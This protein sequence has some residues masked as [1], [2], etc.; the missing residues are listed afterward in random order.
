MPVKHSAGKNR[1]FIVLAIVGVLIIG[2]F[3]ALTFKLIDQE[4]KHVRDVEKVRISEDFSE[5]LI[6]TEDD[7]DTVNSIVDRNPNAIE[8]DLSAV[9]VNDK[10]MKKVGVLKRLEQLSL[11][12]SKV[13]DNGLQY[14]VGMPLVKLDLSGT[15]VTD[16][17][18]D[19]IAKVP[20]LYR[21]DL[22]VTKITDE[23][24]KKLA[25]LKKLSIIVLS[26]TAV[27]DA[28][29]AYLQQ[30]KNLDRI[31]VGSTKVSNDF[32]KC[33]GP[34]KLFAVYC[35]NTAITGDG[36]KKYLKNTKLR[37]M[38]LEHCDIADEDVP[39][40]IAAAPELQFLNVGSTKISDAGLIA[41]ARML[42]L[43]SI[44]VENCRGITETGLKRF[45]QVRPDCKVETHYI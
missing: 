24:L 13:T 45:A 43:K 9:T 16:R 41:L 1:D 30:C 17:G 31:Y 25:P 29:V 11:S 38:S 7:T 34:M 18:L 21:L 22:S 12:H 6:S 4:D 35:E 26:G 3:I 20:T 14:I 33:V 32:L 19:Y 27:T 5:D 23:G 44:R 28:G 40:I 42:T 15:S 37:K 39:A 36:I 10:L 2:N 8:C